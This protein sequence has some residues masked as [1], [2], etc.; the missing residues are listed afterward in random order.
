MDE[1]TLGSRENGFVT[2]LPVPKR[3]SDR[4]KWCRKR[5]TGKRHG[6]QFCSDA[7]RMANY[8]ARTD[9][10]RAPARPDHRP[11]ASGPQLSYFK[12]LRVLA[13][14]FES[15]GMHPPY[16][17][18]KARGVLRPALPDKQRARLDASLGG[19]DG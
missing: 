10:A 9:P 4:C 19:T 2:G 1:I 14:H 15:E 16:A 17:R 5:F 6:A 8:R 12:A 7:C 11:R 18:E 13:A 3:L